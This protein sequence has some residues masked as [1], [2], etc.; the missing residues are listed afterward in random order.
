MSA[1]TRATP[2]AV[3]FHP[4][5]QCARGRSDCRSLGQVISSDAT[6]F[7]CCGEVAKGATP[8]PADE[9]AFCVRGR[10]DRPGVNGTDIRIFIDKMDMSHMTMVLATAQAIATTPAPAPQGEAGK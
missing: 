6:T 1:W 7:V 5:E 10:D 4:P 8:D 3:G 2:L 9:W